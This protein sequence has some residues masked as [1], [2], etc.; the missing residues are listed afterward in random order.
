MVIKYLYIS[1]L[2]F[3]VYGENYH[4]IRGVPDELQHLYYPTSNSSTSWS[5][6][7]DSSIV[8]D[9]SQINDDYCDCP[10][11]SDEP[12]TSACGSKSRFYCQN[13]GFLSR[14]I[15]GFKVNDGVCDCCDCSDEYICDPF[16]KGVM[17]E[18]LNTDF[19]VMVQL[20]LTKFKKGTGALKEL[21]K[22]YISYHD[23][24]ESLELK[25]TQKLQL[26]L[27]IQALNE[28]KD[29]LDKKLYDATIMLNKQLQIENPMVFRFEKINLLYLSSVID[30]FYTHVW[31][32][33]NAHQYLVRLLDNLA[34]DYNRSL[35]D[36]VV[37]QNI[38]KYIAYMQEYKSDIYIDSSL[39]ET[40]KNQLIEYITNE[41][42]DTFVKKNTK[43]SSHE[44]IAKFNVV[45]V[46]IDT[47][48]DYRNQ[49]LKSLEVLLNL[50]T[51]V[52]QNYN[53][54]FQD[55]AVNAFVLS[56]KEYIAMNTEYLNQVDLPTKFIDEFEILH[57]FIKEEAKN[58]IQNTKK[59]LSF[60]QVVK[61][62]ILNLVL[63]IPTHDIQFL[64]DT[65]FNLKS[66]IKMH[67]ENIAILQSELLTLEKDIETAKSEGIL[68]SYHYIEKLLDSLKD[69]CIES[70][71]DSYIYRICLDKKTGSIMQYEDQQYGNTVNIGKFS[72]FYQNRNLTQLS[73]LEYLT[74]RYT[75]S[76]LLTHLVNDSINIGEEEISL[77][78]LPDMNNGLIIE[79]H[80]GDKCWNGPNRSAIVFIRCGEVFRI[81]SVTEPTKC[82]YIF[83][84]TGPLGCNIDFKYEE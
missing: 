79:F 36:K 40:Q 2:I 30:T 14:Y 34:K 74:M 39:D 75:S 50:S 35:K 44:I 23:N 82:K 58:V 51:D 6:L 17:C 12:G 47:K 81:E 54:N 64:R 33:S 76:G 9:I 69:Y 52:M 72:N 10:D 32:I 68:K 24:G 70:Y 18:Q 43:L 62:K 16:N 7:N 55:T 49:V 28:Q 25:Q 61:K 65:I 80:N 19:Q 53:V 59:K 78:N 29:I 11:G 38:K 5:C 73:Y 71:I 21:E 20:E 56:F 41:L 46:M 37:G 15:S 60:L 22:G 57:K 48:I 31:H 84:V 13:D 42:P 26:L 1:I 63:P 4:T 67:Q 83:E 45:R 66:F 77:K 27:D 3:I 8:L